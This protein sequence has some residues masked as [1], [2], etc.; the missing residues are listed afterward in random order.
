MLNIFRLANIIN[1]LKLNI[2]KYDLFIYHITK[3]ATTSTTTSTT[4][5]ADNKNYLNSIPI[6]NLTVLTSSESSS[7]LLYPYYQQIYKKAIFF[8]ACDLIICQILSPAGLLKTSSTT[9]FISTDYITELNNDY[10]QQKNEKNIRH[11]QK[12]NKFFNNNQKIFSRLLNFKESGSNLFHIK[13]NNINNSL[14]KLNKFIKRNMSTIATTTQTPEN[15]IQS[16]EIIRNGSE[17]IINPDGEIIVS[18]GLTD[19]KIIENCT[20]KNIEENDKSSCF[21]SSLADII[22]FLELVGGLKHTKRTG[23]ILR[24]IKDCESISGHMYRMSMMTFLLNGSE[25]LNQ[26]RC[27]ELA[28]V[29]D[30]A[31]SIVGDLTP[32]CG[33]SKEDK[34]KR[35]MD[36][37]ENICNLIQPR[38]ERMWKLFQEYEAAETP[39]SKFV[40]DLDRLDLVLQAFE[41]E[42]R[43]NCIMKHQEFFDSNEGKFDHPFVKKLVDEICEQRKELAN[44]LGA[45]TEMY[46]HK[47]LQQNGHSSSSGECPED[48]SKKKVTTTS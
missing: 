21:T 16:G 30:L 44:K 2:D 10:Q 41:Y 39:E 25:G 42:K 47:Q 13:H 29:H 18:N 32:F 15:P 27:M 35:E 24:D 1:K 23:W 43:D 22:Q 28:L 12:I 26:I 48:L 45:T 17:K 38:G 6:T 19:C 31:E 11:Q 8:S 9:N 3:R 46:E 37:M 7:S 34:K 14:F 20:T 36:A 40:K 4:I 33:V 5:L